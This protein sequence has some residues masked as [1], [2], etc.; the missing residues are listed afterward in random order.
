MTTV[1]AQ[2]SRNG[3]KA[4]PTQQ[5]DGRIA[6]SRH[7]LRP[8]ICMDGAVIFSHGHIFDVMQAIFDGPMS[9][10]EG[11]QPLRDANGSRQTGDAVAHLLTPFPFITPATTDLKD[12]VQARPIRV[13]L[14]F[15]R[16]ANTADL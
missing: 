10:L 3:R 7:D 5:A 2:T 1:V 11:E 14:E 9:S 16:N 13:A 6:Q 8:I 4:S 15:G 12:L